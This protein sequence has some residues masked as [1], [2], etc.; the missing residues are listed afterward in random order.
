MSEAF[1]FSISIIIVILLLA[2]A[3]WLAKKYDEYHL[4]SKHGDNSSQGDTDSS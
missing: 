4:P 1:I 2:C 3:F